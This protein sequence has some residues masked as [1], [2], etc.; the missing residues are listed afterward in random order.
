M[1]SIDRAL[2]PA[3]G[4]LVLLIEPSTSSG[5][6]STQSVCRDLLETAAK[7]G[8]FPHCVVCGFSAE[9][10]FLRFKKAPRAPEIQLYRA[11]CLRKTCNKFFGPRWIQSATNGYLIQ[12]ADPS[13]ET[14]AYLH[15]PNREIPAAEYEDMVKFGRPGR[16]SKIENEVSVSPVPVATQNPSEDIA[17]PNGPLEEEVSNATSV[18]IE[19]KSPSPTTESLESDPTS[20][21]QP[22]SDNSMAPRKGK[23]NA[24][25]Q[26]PQK[27]CEDFS[28]QTDQ[29][30]FDVLEARYQPLL[31]KEQVAAGANVDVTIRRVRIAANLLA[32]ANEEKERL[33]KQNVEMKEKLVTMLE[34]LRNLKEV[35]TLNGRLIKEE[36]DYLS[37]QL[38]TYQNQL[39][40]DVT[41]V[42]EHIQKAEARIKARIEESK[43]LL[44]LE[45]AKTARAN[46]GCRYRKENLSHERRADLASAMKFEL[47]EQLGISKAKATEL[48][49]LVDKK[50]DVIHQLKADNKKAADEKAKI[51]QM[52][53]MLVKQMEKLRFQLGAY[54]AN[55][56][57]LLHK[58][59]RAE[60]PSSMATPPSTEKSESPTDKFELGG[61]VLSLDKVIVSVKDSSPSTPLP[62]F[63]ALTTDAI[64][65]G[66]SA[67]SGWIARKKEKV[68]KEVIEPL[69]ADNPEAAESVQE[70][71]SHD[72]HRSAPPEF[73]KE[74]AAQPTSSTR[75]TSVEPVNKPSVPS[76]GKRD[77]QETSSKP[78]EPPAFKPPRPRPSKPKGQQK[79]N[80]PIPWSTNVPPSKKPHTLPATTSQACRSIQRAASPP[81]PSMI[82]PAQPH[83]FS[84]KNG[85]PQ[86]FPSVPA[87][88]TSSWR[89]APAPTPPSWRT[90]PAPPP[91]FETPLPWHKA[92]AAP[93]P[94]PQNF[95]AF[96]AAPPPSK[97]RSFWE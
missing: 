12:S 31:T 53:Q 5:E 80:G 27:Q 24:R 55:N 60:T 64:E 11:K 71:R 3:Q 54:E 40:I 22:S 10:P 28:S 93:A 62:V 65:I 42:E 83:P 78:R 95:T 63:P 49:K 1:A 85:N 90:T 33:Q 39:K 30:E 48:E 68:E 70:R 67:F 82:L 2:T 34:Q 17:P 6:S 94:Q 74:Q 15:A 20:I 9:A 75:T 43:H 89:A 81:R 79:R 45:K 69:A 97:P 86:F 56:K 25:A 32:R 4:E 35:L 37:Q 19:E 47:A 84:G 77:D 52:N 7:A 16:R 8:S 66:N 18:H 44:E 50:R 36:V 59:V 61:K 51:A 38:R 29:L 26:P 72:N 76:R 91:S 96:P 23:K 88:S 21:E 92:A 14:H 87:S 41:I 73:N 13:F 46:A 58:L 57:D